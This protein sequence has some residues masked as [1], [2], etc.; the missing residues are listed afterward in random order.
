MLRLE[1][2]S[3]WFAATGIQALDNVD[4][5]VESGSIHA[6]VGENGAGKSTLARIVAGDIAPGSGRV[7]FEGE[8]LAPGRVDRALAKGIALVS[9][10]PSLVEGFSL[11]EDA[12]MGAA[13][14]P[15][16][17][18]K[19]LRQA[20]DAIVCDLG[21]K[22]DGDLPVE[23]ASA[24]ERQLARLTGFLMKDLRCLILDEVSAVL[25]YNEQEALH[26]LMKRLAQKGTS[27]I[28]V[29]HLLDEV[30]A[31]ADRTSIL[32]QGRILETIGKRALSTDELALR[33]FGQ[34]GTMRE[35]EQCV[36]DTNTTDTPAEDEGPP[37]ARRIRKPVFSLS[38]VSFKNPSWAPIYELSFSL[39]GGSITA[40]AGIR[41]AG[42]ETLEHLIA[43]ALVP[44][45]GSIE[46]AGKRFEAPLPQHG[47][48]TR[49]RV[50]D[51]RTAG[52]AWIA[53]GRGLSMLPNR[54]SLCD[55]IAACSPRR[56]TNHTLPFLMDMNRLKKAT[57]SLIQEAKIRATG[58]QSCA[59]LS[60]GS[61]RRFANA[62]ELARPARVL[63]AVE[64]F[65]GLDNKAA[66][67][68][69]ESLRAW[70]NK[71]RSVLLV[72]ADI[73][74]LISLSDRILALSDGHIAA[75]ISLDSPQSRQNARD[76]IPPLLVHHASCE[77]PLH[78]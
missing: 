55:S 15:F 6:L 71:D 34:A 63:L 60:G 36:E 67:E 49:S 12:L 78:A 59:S 61:Q 45:D 58:N 62:R 4:L 69:A 24:A 40:I 75:D 14:G 19:A 22:L 33:M 35:Q 48:T 2:I 43:G 18:R 70:C 46:I 51:L 13:T 32:C 66:R 64:P 65:W 20:W 54:L 23:R 9:Q 73:D 76:T 3:H 25:D 37:P 47:R 52:L 21:I 7:I 38:G 74:R 42:I 17:R 5:S 68:L 30:L 29:S 1:G 26:G 16:L 39:E 72:S 10:Y 8:L 28:L 41:D 57:S 50:Q 31:L 27:I 53:G 56:Y 77:E 11:F 44:H